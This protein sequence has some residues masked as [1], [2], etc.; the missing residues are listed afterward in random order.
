MFQWMALTNIE[1][2]MYLGT[3]R[4]Y[5]SD[6]RHHHNLDIL[7]L[8]RELGSDSFTPQVCRSYRSQLLAITYRHVERSKSFVLEQEEDLEGWSDEIGIILNRMEAVLKLAESLT[9]EYRDIFNNSLH[10]S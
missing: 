6:R 1:S 9:R 8:Q 2:M 7:Q 5:L 10:R 4:D 3:P